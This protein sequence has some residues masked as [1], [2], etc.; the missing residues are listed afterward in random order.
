MAVGAL[1]AADPVWNYTVEVTASVSE[2]PPAIT[3]NWA[4]DMNGPPL[5]YTVYRKAPS[6]AAWGNALVSLGGDATSFTDANVA[7]GQPYE[8]QIVKAANGYAGYGYIQ[9][10]IDVALVDHRGTVILI[11]DNTYAADLSDVLARLEQDLVGDGWSVIRHDVG[12]SDSVTSVKGLIEADYL[13]DPADVN[14]VFLFGHVPVPYS[15]LLNPDQHP[16][17][18][19]AW[20]ADVYYG[21][22]EGQWTDTTVNFVSTEDTDPA[23]AARL[24]NVPGDGKFDQT[25]IPGP[26]QLEVG[27]VDLANMPGDLQYDADPSF[28]SEEAL[29]RQYL[30]KDHAFRMAAMTA[31]RRALVGDYIGDATGRAPAASGIRSFAPLFGYGNSTLVNLNVLDSDQQG[32]WLPALAS[33]DYLFVYGC[34]SG[35]YSAIN[36]LGPGQP[37][38]FASSTDLVANDV[39]GVFFMVFGSWL[40][41]WDHSDDFMRAFLATPT[42]GLACVWSGLPHWF[43]HPMGLGETLGYCARLTQ[44]NKSPGLY[45]TEAN[46]CANEVH[47]ALMGDPT[48]RL[49]PVAPPAGLAAAAGQNQV[50]LT[51]VASPDP[52]VIG[53]QVY[54][55]PSSGGPFT[56]LTGSPFAGTSFTDSNPAS[57]STYMVRAEKLETVPSGTYFNASQGLF[58]TAGPSPAATAAARLVN[59]SVRSNAGPGGQTLTVG[60]TVGGQAVSGTLPVLVRG[61]G[62]G[63]Q[64]FGVSETLANPLLTL[65]QNSTALAS[66]DRWSENAAAVSAAEAATGAFQLDPASADAALTLDVSAG[67]Y[68]AQI[69][70]ENGAS[71]AALA[72]VY[73]ATPNGVGA[74]GQPR[75]LNLSAKT[76]VGG[77]AG[78]LTVGFVIDGSG[79]ETVL[80]RGIG[81]GLASLGV[82]GT[83]AA[84]VLTLFDS[85]GAS[86]AANSGWGGDPHLASVFAQ[87]G[88]FPLDPASA[89]SALVVSLPT[90]AY[91]VQIAGANGSAGSALAELYEVP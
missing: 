30:N 74:A 38:N 37:Y 80:V 70:G 76:L 87:V 13:A 55:A 69:S 20:P 18:L 57:G 62:P 53:Y 60:F 42:Y 32:V 22:M 64:P 31:Q 6:D 19:G 26:V 21:D 24:T 16:E 15:G 43:M 68:S 29:L 12:R 4:Q 36:G 85:D 35:G 23:D 34:G 11:V 41:D 61:I 25:A 9:S 52:A 5:S 27:R 46:L 72:E 39:H 51:W 79:A 28:P 14:A 56:R 77:S 1:R 65:F 2:S 66:N 91:T 7:V 67:A 75:L 47:I 84:P 88:A 63:L 83:L 71:G 33:Q 10:G 81:P 90:G 3:L 48:L 54:R 82:S 89:D 59:L 50:V 45:Q 58:C 44:N 17:H 86:L 49:H 8:Y 73:D 40:G 78:P